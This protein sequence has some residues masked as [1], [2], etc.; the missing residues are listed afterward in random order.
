MTLALAKLKIEILDNVQNFSAPKLS[1]D[2][3]SY[4]LKENSLLVLDKNENSSEMLKCI[5]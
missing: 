1:F 3:L 4:L 2:I 5:N